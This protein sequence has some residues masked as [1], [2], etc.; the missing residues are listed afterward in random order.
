M[1]ILKA[2]SFFV[3]ILVFSCGNKNTPTNVTEVS[4]PDSTRNAP[5]IAH[6]IDL[7]K[8]RLEMFWKNDSDQIIGNFSE[9]KNHLAQKNTELLFAMNGGMFT[10][11]R[12]P[13]GL[14][15]ENG[16]TLSKLKEDTAG[17]GNFYMQPNGVFYI[18]QNNTAAVVTT[19][20]FTHS[21]TIK[22]ATQSGPM[23]ISNGKI[24]A[25]F[26]EHST[27]THIRNGVGILPDGKVLFA[28]SKQRLNFYSFAE[29]FKSQGCENALYL[30]GFVS[31]VYLPA[32]DIQQLD[33]SFGVIIGEVLP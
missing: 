20:N 33:G 24:N 13:L 22:Y 28:I 26:G 10:K 8:S 2:F 7:T 25:H 21:S 29:Y 6:T 5:I 1:R 23:L 17:Y 4:T 12:E 30:D 16:K 31:R 19:Q 32:K 11:E 3:L 27:S 9:L 15:I 14:Y 18:T